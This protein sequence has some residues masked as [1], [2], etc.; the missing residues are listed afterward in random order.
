MCETKGTPSIFTLLTLWLANTPT[1]LRM[2]PH[3]LTQK[4]YHL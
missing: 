2:L 1:L 4:L 3:S